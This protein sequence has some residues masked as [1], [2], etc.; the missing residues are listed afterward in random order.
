MSRLPKFVRRR[1]IDDVAGLVV[2][3]AVQWD[4]GIDF[5]TL[6]TTTD[7]KRL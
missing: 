7:W 5:E 6:D 1:Q 4:S 3:L 2:S